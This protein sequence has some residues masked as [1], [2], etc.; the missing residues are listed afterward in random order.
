[1][2]EMLQMQKMQKMLD[3]PAAPALAEWA[4]LISR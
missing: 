1:M 4:M 2:R 3:P